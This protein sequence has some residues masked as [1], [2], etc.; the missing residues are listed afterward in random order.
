MEPKRPRGRPRGYDPEQALAA[1]LGE[2]RARGYSATSLDN[3]S[4]ATKMARPSLYAAFGNKLDIY[5]KAVRQYADASDGRR[6]HLLFGN[7]SL[8]DGLE[9]Y[10]STIIDLYMS[11]KGEPLGCPILSII[12]GEAAAD[13]QI[14]AELTAAVEKIDAQFLRRM[15]MAADAGEIPPNGD[16]ADI[17][18]MLAALQ[19]TLALR[20]R[21]GEHAPG[22]VSFARSYIA[23][24]LKAAG[25]TDHETTTH[26]A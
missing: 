11:P 1:A 2:F 3:L 12:S 18:R 26:R 7:P 8:Q 17:A 16:L 21:A 4:S 25:Y 23:L 9:A 20:A 6:A 22:L 10:F 5:R 24:V 13:P 15:Q 14:G 19:H